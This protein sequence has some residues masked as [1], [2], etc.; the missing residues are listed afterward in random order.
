MA[1][2]PNVTLIRR[3][4]AAFNSGDVATLTELIAKDCVQHMPGQNVFSGEHKG[5]EAILAMY[6]QI[7]ELTEGSYR[8]DLTEVY[9]NDHRCIALYTGTA[10]RNERSVTERH[11]LTF[12]LI[13]GKA[14]DID[15][16]P[17][18]GVVDD[19]FWQ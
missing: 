6:G 19:S 17:L 12:E 5:Q 10:T 8:A 11:A 13:D 9:A 2:H 18:D 15:D 4:F 3:G 14:I 7:A 16:V 1:E